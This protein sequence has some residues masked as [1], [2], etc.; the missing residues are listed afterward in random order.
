[1]ASH[2]IL[3]YIKN[4]L[5]DTNSRKATFVVAALAEVA[6]IVKQLALIVAA[7]VVL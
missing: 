3:I 7:F 5:F 4:L 1:M 6:L 2:M